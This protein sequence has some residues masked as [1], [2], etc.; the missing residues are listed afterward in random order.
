MRADTGLDEIYILNVAN[1]L[2]IKT[3]TVTAYCEHGKHDN[4]TCIECE[5]GYVYDTH[6]FYTPRGNIAYSKLHECELAGLSDDH[7]F[8]R[9]IP[10]RFQSKVDELV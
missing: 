7:T 8:V 3:V 4:Q 2:G 9:Y 5:H 10:K 1:K 6:K